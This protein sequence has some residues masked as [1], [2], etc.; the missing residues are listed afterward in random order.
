MNRI[1]A[2]VILCIGTVL[3][4]Y[5]LN[6]LDSI[7]SSLTR[8]FTGTPTDESIWLLISGVLLLVIGAG[9]LVRTSKRT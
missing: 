5:G 4:I 9:A 3:S 8:F 2:T 6:A 7:G 1:L